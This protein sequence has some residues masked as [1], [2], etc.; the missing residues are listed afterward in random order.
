[1]SFDLNSSRPIVIYPCRWNY[2]LIG[3]AE[4][5]L[6][7]CIADVV[8]AVEHEIAFSKLSDKGNY[9]S[10]HVKVLVETEAQRNDI[11]QRLKQQPSVRMVL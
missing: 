11:F 8:G 1:M 10:L 6:R 2:T 9:C 7:Q 5:D 3:R 4:A